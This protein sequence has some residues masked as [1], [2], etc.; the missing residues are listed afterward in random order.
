M[1][2]RIAG[3]VIAAVLIAV[4]LMPAAEAQ[5]TDTTTLFESAVR[6]TD[7]G[8]PPQSRPHHEPLCVQLVI[9]GEDVYDDEGNYLYSYSDYVDPCRW[10]VD[11]GIYRVDDHELDQ[12]LAEFLSR[13]IPFFDEF[14]DDALLLDFCRLVSTGEMLHRDQTVAEL[15]P[16]STPTW[17]LVPI[18]DEVL[19]IPGTLLDLWAA[20]PEPD[21]EIDGAPPIRE[22]TWVQA[23]TWVWIEEI[24][25]PLQAVSL[26]TAQTARLVVQAK[27]ARIVW[28]FGDGATATCEVDR[29]IIWD[30]SLDPYADAGLG[31]THIYEQVATEGLTIVANVTFEGEQVLQSKAAASDPWPPPAWLPYAE[32]REVPGD[33]LVRVLEIASRN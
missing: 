6:I 1:T 4:S 17:A 13:P 25:T 33:L 27:V 20:I 26:N 11:C 31:C 16:Y 30:D 15:V 21:I 28:D 29:L 12:V 7:L 23:S 3:A 9:R 22:Q 19:D 14:E 5:T 24:E 18:A 10:Q 32:T 8:Q 2:R